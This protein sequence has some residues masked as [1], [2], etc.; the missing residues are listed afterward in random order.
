MSTIRKLLLAL[1]IMKKRYLAFM[2]IVRNILLTKVSSKNKGTISHF[3][4]FIRKIVPKRMYLITKSSQKI[5]GNFLAKYS[6]FILAP[7]FCIPDD[8]DDDD[9][10]KIEEDGDKNLVC[11]APDLSV[12]IPIKESYLCCF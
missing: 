6:P 10:K 11:V 1:G 5:F 7:D 2:I 12:N 8:Q 3:D 9:F 4:C